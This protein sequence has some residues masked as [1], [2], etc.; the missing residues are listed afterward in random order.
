[1]TKD[2]AYQMKTE[3]QKVLDNTAA[4]VDLVLVTGFVY[5]LGNKNSDNVNPV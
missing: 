2:P 1:M 5:L 4:C 3:K